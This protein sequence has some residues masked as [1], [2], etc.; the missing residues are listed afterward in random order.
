MGQ[1]SNLVPVSI[2]RN[3]RVKMRATEPPVTSTTFGDLGLAEDDIEDF[4]DKNTYAL[5]SDDN[6]SQSM[7]IVGRQVKNEFGG[8][9]DLVAIDADGAIVVI[10]IKRDPKD[11]KARVEAFEM[12]SIRY[13]SSFTRIITPDELA[14]QVFTPYLQRYKRDDLDGKDVHDHAKKQIENFLIVNKCGSTFNQKQKIMLIASGF[15][16]ETI[17]ACA[18]LRKS[19]IDITCV[20]I[21]PMTHVTQNFLLIETILPPPELD[22]FLGSVGKVKASRG[23]IV[24]GINTPRSSRAKFMTTAEMMERGLL[25]KE[26]AVTVKGYPNSMAIIEDYRTVIYNGKPTSWNEWAKDVTKWS[27]VNIYA[28]VMKDGRTLE[29]IRTA[30]QI[31]LDQE[32]DRAEANDEQ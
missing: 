14:E 25:K 20:Q 31:L 30:A 15:D 12:Q 32:R 19:G 11:C 9:C 8:R 10:E 13:A 7:L 27:A 26:D 2:S 18:W 1:S 24:S 23:T 5:I 6:S 3:E 16:P 21:S 17:S 4:L 28:N 22:D 29:E